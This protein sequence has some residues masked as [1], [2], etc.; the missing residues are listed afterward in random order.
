[1]SDS[2]GE[3]LVDQQVY[4]AL[5]TSS[6]DNLSADHRARLAKAYTEIGLIYQEAGID[7]LSKVAALQ[8]AWF[9]NQLGGTNRVLKTG[10]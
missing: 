2:A 10:M 4:R 6:Y 1:M 8:A 5:S 3:P 7:T 9:R